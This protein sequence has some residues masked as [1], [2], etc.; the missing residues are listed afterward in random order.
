MLDKIKEIFF[1]FTFLHPSDLLQIASIIKPKSLNK[2]EFLIREGE[3]CYQIAILVKGLLRHYHIDNDG[4]EKT[5]LFVCEKNISV[6]AFTIFMNKP[7]PEYV[8]AL[9]DTIVLL[10]DNREFERIAKDNIRLLNLQNQFLKD[11]IISDI[12][13]IKSLTVYTPEE[14]FQNFCKTFPKLEQRIRQKY[15]ASY[16]GITPTSLSRMKA[17]INYL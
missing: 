12:E 17:R 1:R 14:R 9:E 2:G 3:Y 13:Q 15:L 6:S 7:S 5:V 4:N 16:L 10:A 11:A 8:V